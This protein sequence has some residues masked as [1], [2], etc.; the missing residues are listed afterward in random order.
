[1]LIK[2]VITCIGAGIA[3]DDPLSNE[4]DNM[5]RVAYGSVTSIE[6]NV[7]SC[8]LLAQLVHYSKVV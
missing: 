4:I 3:R 6:R 1:M 8:K 2:V 7:M 5:S